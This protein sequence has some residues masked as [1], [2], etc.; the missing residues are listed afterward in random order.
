MI[1]LHCHSSASDGSLTPEE[2]VIKAYDSGISSLALTDHD[3]ISGLS[4][5]KTTAR[6][7]GIELIS[8]IEFNCDCDSGELHILGLFIDETN[9][10]LLK[11][12]KKLE[13]YRKERNEKLIE[14]LTKQGIK[15]DMDDLFCHNDRIENIG[16]PNFARALYKNGYAK[17]EFEAYSKYLSESNL[18]SIERK[19]ISD[20]EALDIIHTAGGIAVL[21]H[22]DQLGIKDHK[23][24]LSFISD[25]KEKGLDGIEIF[26]T[27]YK[28]NIIKRYKGIARKYSLLCSGGSDFHGESKYRNNKLGFYGEKKIIPKEILDKMKD[29]MKSYRG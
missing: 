12:I 24:L 28:K 17:N 21:A 20:R 11:L 3:T 25:L 5:A 1:D 15:L 8:G 10:E 18:K 4:K 2:L 29:F 14:L 27:G 9:A 26:Y 23:L 13:E 6:K 7:V 19:K 16:K 22:P